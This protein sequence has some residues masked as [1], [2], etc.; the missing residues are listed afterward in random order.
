MA[1]V[2]TAAWRRVG[3]F[4]ESSMYEDWDFY[5]RLT[6]ADFEVGMVPEFLAEYRLQETSRNADAANRRAEAVTEIVKAHR[7]QFERFVVEAIVSREETI[8]E[9]RSTYA[10]LIATPPTFGDGSA[11]HRIR[12]PLPVEVL[13]EE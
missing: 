1:L 12:K 11:S 10:C 9:L 5:L 3:G 7:D 6:G 13:S 2:R 4:S 8:F